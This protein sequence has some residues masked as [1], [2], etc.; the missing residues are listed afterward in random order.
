MSDDIISSLINQ[1]DNFNLTNINDI[2]PSDIKFDKEDEYCIYYLSQIIANHIIY[3]KITDTFTILQFYK[4][5]YPQCTIHESKKI[6]FIKGIIS[7][8]Q[9]EI[10]NNPYRS[11]EDILNELLDNVE[12]KY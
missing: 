5:T 2:N 8:F 3:N 1:I 7:L 12:T 6:N 4:E 10:N 9:N 11:K